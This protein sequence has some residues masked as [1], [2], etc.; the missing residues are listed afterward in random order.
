MINSTAR[1][2]VAWNYYQRGLHDLAINELKRLLS[3]SP[4][5]SFLHALLAACLLSKKRLHAAEYEVGQ[6][7]KLDPHESFALLTLARVL[8]FRNRW[9]QALEKCEEVLAQDPGLYSAHL[10]QSQIH[11]LAHDPANALKSLNAAAILAPDDIDVLNG[12]GEYYLQ[13]GDLIQAEEYTLA[14][15]A[16]YADDADAHLT[17]AKIKLQ[18]GDTAGAEDHVK[19]VMT[20]DPESEAALQMFA[21]IKMR[22]SWML[23]LWWRWNVWMQQRGQMG[24]I[25]VLIGA[26]ILFNFLRLVVEDMGYPRSATLIGYL[27]WV[28]VIY[29]WVGIPLYHRQL[30]SELK[31]FRFSSDY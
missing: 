6:A 19:F 8:V 16:R 2:N 31:K 27:W 13:T 10:L 18:R 20:N 25:L 9:Q 15:L 22:R 1:T 30:Q 29:S 7:L 14:V 12:F 24:T 26:F 23:G 5:E 17:M 3:E 28:V 21:N 4:N 11:L